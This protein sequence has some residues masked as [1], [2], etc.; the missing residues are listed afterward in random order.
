MS[1]DITIYQGPDSDPQAIATY[2]PQLDYILSLDACVAAWLKTKS[3]R[4]GSA[5]TKRAYT[6][7]INGFRALLQSARP[8]PLDLDST[9]TRAIRLAAESYASGNGVSPATFNQ[10]LAILSSFYTYAIKQEVIDSNPIKLIDRRPADAKDAALPMGDTE[11][12]RAFAAID[13]STPEGLRDY[14]L[15]SLAV[16]T[17]R[18]S[19]E[20]ASLVWGDIRLS[21]RGRSEK[22]LITWQRC[23]GNKQLRD[24]IEPRTKATL[25]AYLHKLYGADLGKLAKDA[26]IFVSLSKNNHRGGLSIQ[27][28]S[29]ICLKHLG[30][31]K[32]HTT[33]H[34][35][36][37][38]MEKAGAS[39]SDIGAKLGHASLKTTSD[40]MKR[41]HSAENPHAAKLGEMFGI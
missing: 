7:T 3:E 5:K 10:R 9:D 12:A 41:L 20:L 37:V 2:T 15:L 17:G 22:M 38:Q 25:L 27:A 40:Y 31:S 28:V 29:D 23:K 33:R 30:T 19:R 35:F 18:R 11:I 32:V 21:G 1:Q 14:A 8:V 36:A 4:T 6:E 13:R 34:T 16:T 26:P 39:L 24:E